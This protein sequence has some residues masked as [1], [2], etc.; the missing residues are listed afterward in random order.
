VLPAESDLART[1]IKKFTE[2]E[3]KVDALEAKIT[4]AIS[5][6]QALRRELDEFL[7]ALDVQ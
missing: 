4:D 2:Q 1:Y 7:L 6:E 5:R 3:Q